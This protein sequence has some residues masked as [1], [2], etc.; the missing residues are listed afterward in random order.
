MFGVWWFKQGTRWFH[1]CTNLHFCANGFRSSQF[2]DQDP[3][4]TAIYIW[5]K[6]HGKKCI[7]YETLIFFITKPNFVVQIELLSFV[8]S[9]LN[10][11]NAL[12]LSLVWLC[13][14]IILVRCAMLNIS[15][16]K[17]TKILHLF[18]KVCCKHSFDTFYNVFLGKKNLFLVSFNIVV[19]NLFL[20]YPCSLPFPA[21][22]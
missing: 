9:S 7:L 14:K 2:G 13:N 11:C 10:N 16:C 3:S 15:F 8:S 1:F 20:P 21:I 4:K 22:Q 12:A 17:Q 6:W 19:L 18:A 5:R